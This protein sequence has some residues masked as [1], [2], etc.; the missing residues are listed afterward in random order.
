MEALHITAKDLR[1][2]PLADPECARRTWAAM[3]RRWPRVFAACLMGNHLHVLVPYASGDEA[4]WLL[5][6]L[7]RMPH[8]TAPDVE[9]S[10]VRGRLKLMRN[11]RYIALNPCRTPLCADPLEWLWSTHREAFGAAAEPWLDEDV[12]ELFGSPDG[13]HRYVSADVSVDIEGTSSP[14]PAVETSVATRPVADI[15]RACLAAYRLP[16]TGLRRRGPARA[17]FFRLAW[18]QGWR[19]ARHLGELVG[20]G[21]L[22][23]RRAWSGHASQASRACLG[24]G[25]LL[26]RAV[27]SDPRE[28]QTFVHAPSPGVIGSQRTSGVRSGPISSRR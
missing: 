11:V 18:E 20:A 8:W 21:P 24:D 16:N 5:R 22:A 10:H 15:A 1:E 27:P 17:D 4:D 19:N 2:Y 12:V 23:V 25:R 28:P 3:R 14:E 6:S 26:V 9:A 7:R 13:L